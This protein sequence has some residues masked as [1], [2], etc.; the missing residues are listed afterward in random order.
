MSRD[1]LQK[2]AALEVDWESIGLLE[3]GVFQEPYF[4]TP[5]KAEYVG[6]LG[7]DGIHFVLLPGDERVFCVDPSMG[8]IGTYVL[9]VAKDLREFLSFL[10]Y[11]RDAN[12]LSQVYWLSKE[13][14]D[15]LLNEAAAAVWPGSD[16]FFARQEQTLAEIAR[17]FELK[18]QEPYDRIK[19]I[20]AAFAPSVLRFSEE[21]Y[22]ITGAER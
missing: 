19:S 14:F 9:P 8:E 6:R 7:V 4:C 16:A 11:C 5:L 1:D 18:A 17:I 15:R 22:E 3:P 12:P 13:R 21:Y 10:L 20:Q 2:L